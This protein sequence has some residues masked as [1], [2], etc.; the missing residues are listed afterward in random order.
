MTTK[1][2][3]RAV[4]TTG[5]L[6]VLMLGASTSFGQAP[7]VQQIPLQVTP[8]KDPAGA[9]LIPLVGPFG[10]NVNLKLPV[11]G[12]GPQPDHW[13]QW[14]AHQAFQMKFEGLPVQ[15]QPKTKSDLGDEPSEVWVDAKP[16][17]NS[18]D[19]TFK[20]KLKTGNGN[21]TVFTKYSVKIAGCANVNDPVIIVGR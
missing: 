17:P 11:P 20:V 10:G 3:V 21:E 16:V 6:A 2:T 14:T 13:I 9:C 8:L 1:I 18:T 4:V 12:S 5:L 15:G 7:L 19:F